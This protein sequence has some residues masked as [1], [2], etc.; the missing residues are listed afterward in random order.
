ME[1]VSKI[2][3]SSTINASVEKVWEIFNAPEHNVIWNTGHPDWHTPKST[4][5]LRVGGK[6][7]HTM[8]AKDGS[9]SFDFNGTYNIIKPY[10][11]IDYTIEGGR[12][13]QVL[14]ETI[15]Q[16][17]KVTEVFE[18]EIEN[19]EELQKAGWQGILDNFK[20]YVEKL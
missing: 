3:V 17:V 4:N 6:F 20:R 2:I 18:A 16:S 15:G 14:F 19:S 13:V 1:N 5:D 12:K 11:L 10:Q 8:A 9:A 7:C